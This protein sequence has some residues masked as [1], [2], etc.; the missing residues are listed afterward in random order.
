[1]FTDV[2]T[3]Q[4]PGTFLSLHEAA[5]ANLG[6]IPKEIPYDQVKAVSIGV[7]ERGEIEEKRL[8]G[9]GVDYDSARVVPYRESREVRHSVPPSACAPT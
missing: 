1:M 3:D 6:G 9:S 7:A 5:Y 8:G 2:A 4:K